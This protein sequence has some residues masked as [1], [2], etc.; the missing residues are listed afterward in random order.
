[1]GNIFLQKYDPSLE[2]SFI[3]VTG[4]LNLVNYNFDMHLNCNMM[5]LVL[6]HSSVLSI[7]GIFGE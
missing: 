4:P 5:V 6:P 2:Q 1:M 3:L 7:Y